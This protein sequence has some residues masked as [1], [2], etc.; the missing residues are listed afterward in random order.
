MT[1]INIGT[2]KGN[3]Q[4]VVINKAYSKI[5]VKDVYQIASTHFDDF[6]I[7]GW[8]IAEKKH[9]D[10]FIRE[11]SKWS[12]ETFDEKRNPASLYK[13]KEELDELI[14]S[15]EQY[16]KNP[17]KDNEIKMQDE[18]ADCFLILFDSAKDF[19][20][21][22]TDILEFMKS[23]FKVV[24]ERKNWIRNENGSYQHF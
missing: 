19:G 5:S 6:I 4:N 10:I 15:V 16:L 1:K 9:I 24:K 23:K 2:T 11:V 17:S 22:F 20:Y 12:K 14:K 3:L 18:Y 21:L 8:C 13:L 7:I